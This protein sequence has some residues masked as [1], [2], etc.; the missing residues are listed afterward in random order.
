MAYGA[1]HD[2]LGD[3]LLL[4][5]QV[6]DEYLMPNP[7]PEGRATAIA[8]MNDPAVSQV[9]LPERCYRTLAD[10]QAPPYA[11]CAAASYHHATARRRVRSPTPS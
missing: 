2:L 3:T 4:G 1:L 8:R 7:T 10:D 9:S 5:A 11:W 6:P